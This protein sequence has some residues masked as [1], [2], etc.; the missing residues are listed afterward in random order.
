M[1]WLD[2]E[3]PTDDEIDRL[4]AMLGLHPLAVEDSK[5][6]DQRPKLDLYDGYAVSIDF[7]VGDNDSLAEVHS[8]YAATYL[9]TLHRDPVP[10]LE[11]LRGSSAF[12]AALSGDPLQVLYRL[13][14]ALYGSCDA[15][16]DRVDDRL[17]DLESDL[18]ASP[19]VQHLTE[20]SDIKRRIAELKRT[21]H[22]S[23]RIPRRRAR[24][25]RRRLARHDR[26]QPT[27]RPR[28]R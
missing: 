5:E 13:L 10:V 3:S 28:S 21:T 6:F 9:V 4:G 14:D 20:I 22:R 19:N 18:L 7:G 25:G 23:T 8:Y 12:R 27:L 15:L 2:V 11:S 24:P 17:D 1:W 16:V 26:R